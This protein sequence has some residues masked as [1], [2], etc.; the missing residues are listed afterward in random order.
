M[1]TVWTEELYLDKYSTVYVLFTYKL[2]RT[3]DK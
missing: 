3:L 2:Y 1:R